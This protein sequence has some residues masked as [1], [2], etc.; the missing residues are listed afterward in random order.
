VHAAGVVIAPGPL[1]D[2][3]P[4][5][6]QES[7]GSGSDGDERVVVTQYDMN[8]LEKAGMLKMDFL[9]LTTL[10]VIHDR[11]ALH[12]GARG[13]RLDL[14]AIPLD[15]E[16]TYRACCAAAA[17]PACSSSSRRWPRTWCAPCAPTASTTSSPP[18]R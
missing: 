7:K 1:D 3:V 16:P 11:E 5:C 2:Y 9:G 10:T 17:P 4:V 8:A 18:T 15:D 12:Q 6:T 13:E 14:D